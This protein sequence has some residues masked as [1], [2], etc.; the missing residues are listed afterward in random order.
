[1]KA[2]RYQFTRIGLVY[3]IALL[4][5]TMLLPIN[6]LAATERIVLPDKESNGETISQTSTSLAT[7]DGG[8]LFVSAVLS[9]S[10]GG[11]DISLTKIAKDGKLSWTKTYGGSGDEEARSIQQTTD[12]GFI[13]TGY[14]TSKG[15]GG[16]D[17]Y[18]LYINKIGDKKWEAAA[19]DSHDDEGIMVQQINGGDF[20]AVGYSLRQRTV[21]GSEAKSQD[22]DIMAVRY[23][24]N[25]K[26]LW[27]KYYGGDEDDYA[28]SIQTNKN[29][30]LVIAG[31]TR[32]YS[33]GTWDIY[34]IKTIDSGLVTWERSI[35]GTANYISTGIQQTPDNGYLVMGYLYDTSSTERT[36]VRVRMDSSGTFLWQQNLDDA[37]LYGNARQVGLSKSQ[38]DDNISQK[39]LSTN[40]P[41]QKP[42][43][44]KTWQ[45]KRTK[46]PKG[47][48]EK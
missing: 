17:L 31:C 27:Q 20:V 1:M 30:G 29:G 14:T 39:N 43:P 8:Q 24:R 2:D 10:N 5:M 9:G 42:E 38:P 13:I 25:G 11:K 46:E 7:K 4:I 48:D 28:C 15:S 34:V 32:S 35:G 33:D 47:D 19:G 21:E 22:A 12:E 36:E 3:I 44:K 6:V 41:P 45:G 18:M 37:S 16:R 26:K 23:D 40:P